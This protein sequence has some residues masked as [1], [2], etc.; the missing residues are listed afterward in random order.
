MEFRGVDGVGADSTSG[1]RG[2][3]VAAG[4]GLSCDGRVMSSNEG[5][6]RMP[7]EATGV[8]GLRKEASTE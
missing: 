3:G 5:M 8:G 1:V 6:G 7:I 4:C 2:D